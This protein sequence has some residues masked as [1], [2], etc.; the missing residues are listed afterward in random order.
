MAINIAIEV[1]EDIAHQL[2]ASWG[3][4]SQWALKVLALEAYRSGV[5]TEAQVQWMLNLPSR[6]ELEVFL[7]RAQ[8]YLD[9]TE[10]DLEHDIVA[11]RNATPR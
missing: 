4:I 2:E 3:D 1:P 11:I 5:V 10:A 8:A 7:N 6:W 9:Y